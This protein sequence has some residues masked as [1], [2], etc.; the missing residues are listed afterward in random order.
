MSCNHCETRRQ[1]LR[2]IAARHGLDSLPR[3]GANKDVDA[4]LSKLPYSVHDE[5]SATCRGSCHDLART[6]G[7]LP[8]L[9][10]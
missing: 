10:S 8:R 4:D 7:V 9:A 6:A 1:E 3:W 5:T 2:D